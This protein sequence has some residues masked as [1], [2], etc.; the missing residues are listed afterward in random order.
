[1]LWSAVLSTFLRSLFT[2]ATFLI[3]IPNGCVCLSVDGRD[4]DVEKI[5]EDRNAHRISNGRMELKGQVHSGKESACQC[6]RGK[7]HG[8]DPCVRKILWSRK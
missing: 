7:K 3:T 4:S 5:S 8:F 6:R 2:G 1:M